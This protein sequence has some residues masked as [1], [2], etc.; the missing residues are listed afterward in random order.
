MPN[1]VTVKL[2]EA[3]GPGKFQEAQDIME[4]E[5]DPELKD[6][7]VYVPKKLCQKIS[8]PILLAVRGRCMEPTIFN[9]NLV[10]VDCDNKTL[11]SDGIFV[12]EFPKNHYNKL[13]G[14]QTK[15]VGEITDQH[16][17]LGTDNPSHP[18]YLVFYD[19]LKVMGRVRAIAR[20]TADPEMCDWTEVD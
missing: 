19:A 11:Q 5:P 10:L 12:F 4:M 17:M 2:V 20:P 7:S 15:R 16:V 1:L 8:R 14:L 9:G 18:N 6:R 3:I 13:S